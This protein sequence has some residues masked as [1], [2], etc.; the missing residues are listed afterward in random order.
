MSWVLL[1]FVGAPVHCWRRRRQHLAFSSSL[2]SASST[3]TPPWTKWH[4]V[5]HTMSQGLESTCIFTVQCSYLS[6]WKICVLITA[7]C[8]QKWC[9]TF[10]C[11]STV[12]CQPFEAEFSVFFGMKRLPCVRDMLRDNTWP[13]RNHRRHQRTCEQLRLAYRTRSAVG[14]CECATSKVDVEM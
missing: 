8:Y 14:D 10:I 1:G 6:F 7:H 11:V 9:V 4:K 5:N 3:K 12:N 2:L 13:K